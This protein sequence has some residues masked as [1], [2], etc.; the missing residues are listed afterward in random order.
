MPLLHSVRD[1]ALV[2][3]VFVRKKSGTVYNVTAF[4]SFTIRILSRGYK[5][6]AKFIDGL[7]LLVKDK[8]AVVDF[9]LYLWLYIKIDTVS[10]LLTR[11]RSW[12][13]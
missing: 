8:V 10:L 12:L 5:S 2:V 9:R 3:L 7:S 11:C 6:A 1:I 4:G 13:H